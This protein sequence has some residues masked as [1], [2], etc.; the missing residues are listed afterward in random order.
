MRSSPLGLLADHAAPLLW[1]AKCGQQ[2]RSLHADGVTSLLECF[3]TGFSVGAFQ[4]LGFVVM[5]FGIKRRPMA[6]VSVVI[7]GHPAQYPAAHYIRGRSHCLD[8]SNRRLCDTPL[9]SRVAA[10]TLVAAAAL[11]IILDFV[12]VPIFRRL[13]IA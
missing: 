11:A 10:G 8:P 5:V 6:M 9:P 3:W 2:F 4:V 7:C 13:T 12:R 1:A